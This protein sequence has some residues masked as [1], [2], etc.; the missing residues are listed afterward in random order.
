MNTAM[1]LCAGFGTRLG[2]LTKNTPKPMLL[3]NKKPLLEY[4]IRHLSGFG[5]INIIINLHYLADKITNYF[6][7]GSNFGVKINYIYEKQPLGTAGAVKNAQKFL[8]GKEDFLVLYGDIVCNEDYSKFYNFHKSKTNAAATIILHERA[9]SNSVVEIDENN[10]IIR[11]IER[12]KTEIKDKKQ[13]WVNSG[14]YCFNNKILDMIP[15]SEFCDFPNDIFIDM[16]SCGIIYGYP[17]NFY[18]CAIDSAERY[19][20]AKEDFAK[21][22]IF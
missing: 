6:G 2:E 13:N 16:V 17:L 22:L 14:L 4:T 15:E 8:K 7:N 18:R 3:I 5:I 20:R 12:P 1:I 11:F 10:K 19:K 9:N 21:G